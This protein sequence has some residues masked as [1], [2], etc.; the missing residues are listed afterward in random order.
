MTIY[1]VNDIKHEAFLRTIKNFSLHKLVVTICVTK[2][3]QFR[4]TVRKLISKQKTDQMAE[5]LCCVWQ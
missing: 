2:K 4:I 1:F 3:F 5:L